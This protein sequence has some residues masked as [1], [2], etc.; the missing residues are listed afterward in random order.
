MSFYN[1]FN[2]VAKVILISYFY[3]VAISMIQK[4]WAYKYSFHFKSHRVDSLFEVNILYCSFHYYWYSSLI[5]L[6]YLIV[7]VPKSNLEI[8]KNISKA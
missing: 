5:I 1:T 2:N 4:W 3:T 6:C 7:H 8:L